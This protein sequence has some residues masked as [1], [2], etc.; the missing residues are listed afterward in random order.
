MYNRR[1]KT[2]AVQT[3]NKHGTWRAISLKENAVRRSG[4]LTHAIWHTMADSV[5]K[6]CYTTY[7][8]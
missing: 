7:Y 2:R 6:S 5:I 8:V 3:R 1:Q 4:H